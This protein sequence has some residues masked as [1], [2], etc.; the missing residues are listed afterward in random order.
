[1]KAFAMFIEYITESG[2]SRA[3]EHSKGRNIGM[4]TAFRGSD[5][6]PGKSPEAIKKINHANNHELEGHI[7]KAGYGFNKVRGRYT[8]NFGK[9]NAK[10]QDE[11]SYF[12]HGKKGDD[13]GEL[14]K[15]LVHHGEK[16]NQDSVL[17]KAHNEEHANLIGTNHTGFPGHGVH[18]NVGHWNPHRTGEFHTVIK[19]GG[20]NSG[21]QAQK[22]IRQK[23][24][25]K[26]LK[27]GIAP[28]HKTFAF[29]D[30]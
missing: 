11:Q 19:G 17:H 7:R 13:H 2:L 5:D 3:Y 26:T 10:S 28:I 22:T 20:V 6:H 29:E 18:Q 24:S 9:P 15:F 1:M 23:G 27:R 12:V 30:K 8:E 25:G 21:K 16:H 4:I 14:K